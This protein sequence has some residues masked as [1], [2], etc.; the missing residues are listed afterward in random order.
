MYHQVSAWQK[1]RLWSLIRKSVELQMIKALSH[2]LMLNSASLV[3]ASCVWLLQ[4]SLWILLGSSSSRPSNLERAENKISYSVSLY[5]VSFNLI[6]IYFFVLDFFKTF[7][8][9]CGLFRFG[10]KHSKNHIL[11]IYSVQLETAVI[12]HSAPLYDVC[13]LITIDLDTIQ[14]I[15]PWIKLTNQHLP[16]V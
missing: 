12:W 4:G 2:L 16:E 15:M 3:V 6:A 7:Y 10:M 8:L 9:M 1:I 11:C 13:W 5:L 14:N